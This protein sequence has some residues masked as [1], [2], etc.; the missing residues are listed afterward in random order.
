MKKTVLFTLMLM[1]STLISLNIAHSGKPLPPV[2]TEEVNQLLME[3][4]QDFDE[5]IDSNLRPSTSQI[6]ETL[7]AEQRSANESKIQAQ[8][9]AVRMEALKLKF[10]KF[11]TTEKGKELVREYGLNTQVD[12]NFSMIT[13]GEQGYDGVNSNHKLYMSDGV[14]VCKYNEDYVGFYPSFAAKI[15]LFGS[16]IPMNENLECLILETQH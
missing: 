12:L 7:K 1:I 16:E 13:R 2:G 8:E 6:F 14:N 9:V 3:S 5:L 15:G 4:S 11:L 10:Y